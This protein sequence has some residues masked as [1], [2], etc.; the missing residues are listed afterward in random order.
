[1]SRG[2]PV[3]SIVASLLSY[4]LPGGLIM[5]TA[6]PVSFST[7]LLKIGISSGLLPPCTPVSHTRGAFVV[8]P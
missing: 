3:A 7:A 1:M 2:S 4:S 6:M 5:V 8:S